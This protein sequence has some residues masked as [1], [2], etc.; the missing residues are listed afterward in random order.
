MSSVN[1][2][3]RIVLPYAEALIESGQLNNILEKMTEDLLLISCSLS[4]SDSLKS[5]LSN[6]L[7]KSAIKKNTLKR[8]YSRQIN[9]RVLN[10]LFILVERRRIDLLGDIIEYYLILAN[11]L[12]TIVVANVS[13]SIALTDLQKINLEQKLKNITN[14]KHVKLVITVNSELIGGFIIKIGSKVIDNSLYGQLSQITSYL[15]AIVR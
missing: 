8:L 2:P 3:S 5:F 10:F 7:I 11:K 14:S 4:N 6:P 1:S 13:T 12:K 9:N 15:N